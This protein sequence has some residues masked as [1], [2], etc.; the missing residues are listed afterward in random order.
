MITL[1]IDL[2][3]IQE[4][5]DYRLDFSNFSTLSAVYP[6]AIDANYTSL[7]W[8]PKNYDFFFAKTEEIKNT[9]MRIKANGDVHLS[10]KLSTFSGHCK[11]DYTFYP[12]DLLNCTLLL[13]SKC[14]QETLFCI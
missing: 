14:L 5:N 9:I 6:T 4:W 8:L 3:L 7:V 2:K 1:S 10:T 13:N 12:V 11:V